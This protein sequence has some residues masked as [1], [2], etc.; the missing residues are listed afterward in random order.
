MDEFSWSGRETQLDDLA[1]NKKIIAL[2]KQSGVSTLFPTQEK[3]FETNVLKG[4]NLILAVPTSSGKTLVAEICMLRRILDGLGKALY[5]VPLRSLA[6]EKYEEFKKYESLGI[7]IAMSIGDYDSK[8]TQLSEADIVVLTT[9]RADSIIRHKPDWLHNISIIIVDEIHLINDPSRG[10]TLEMVLA[11]MLQIL[12]EIQVVGLSATISNS[13][14][15]AGWLNAELV[16]SSWRPIDL[17]EGVYYDGEIKFGDRSTR[18][19]PRKRKD[20]IA[21]LTCDILEENGQVL[22]FVSSRRS[23]VAVCKKIASSIRPYLSK[24]RLGLL[25]DIAKRIDSG[26]S[27]PESSKILARLVSMGVAFHHAGLT[28]QERSIVEEG[29][30][31]DLLKVIVATPTLAAGVN[32]PA[33]RAIIRDYRRFE[34][35]RGSYPIPVLEYKQMA[36]RAGRPK[37]DKYGEA[38]IFARTESEQEFLLEYYLY[39]EPESIS[40]KLAS[41]EA[42][43]THILSAIATEMTRNRKEIDKLIDGTFFSFQSE[44][45]EIDHHVSSALDFLEQ[46]GLIEL[47]QE[48][49]YATPLGQR[50]SRLYIHPYT[51]IMFRDALKK[52]EEINE[53]GFLHLVAH[54][55]D[56]PLSYVTQSEL[57][58]VTAYLETNSDRFLVPIPDSWED[59]DGYARFLAEVKTAYVLQDWISETSENHLTEQYNVGMGDIHRY[60][61]SAEWLLYSAAEIAKIVG[62]P[63]I[64]PTL[65]ELRSRVKYGIKN[66]LL[67]LASL[68]GIGRIRSR[69]MY[70]HGIK[71]LV[72]L[73]NIPLSNLARIPT[74]GTSVATS[75]K[76]QL[77]LD[78]SHTLKDEPE[79]IKEENSGSL[80]TLLEDF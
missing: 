63:S 31:K 25:N 53:I 2:L 72:D 78:I 13:D 61:R 54:S 56:Q 37:Y 34:Q 36:G 57:E 21:D 49:M 1:I 43:Q 3:A 22:V 9:E 27:I 28:N 64:I 16:K 11:K 24:E 58:E 20:E 45:W 32:L 68:R 8:G 74:I 60:V 65:Q 71:G 15:I 33:R 18:S 50:T 52:A 38:I 62:L 26:P 41:Q 14:E 75:I 29:F 77:G 42:V 67:E 51:A 17:K 35:N 48:Q 4:Q 5:L 10:P 79:A 59:P 6:Q 80:Q 40:S 44:R 12:P 30:K 39:S 73:Y 70:N 76:K 19:I 46:G 23:T 7:T 69:M 47:N 55:P 66:E